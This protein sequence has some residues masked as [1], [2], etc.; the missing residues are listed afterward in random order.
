MYS[1]PTV[2]AGG[3]QAVCDGEA[4]TLLGSGATTYAWDNGITDGTIFTPTA[5]NTYTVTGTDA[6]GCLGTDAVNLT[7]NTSYYNIIPTSLCTG[8]SILAGGAYQKVSGTFYDSL[9]SSAGCDS[10]IETVLTVSSQITINLFLSVCYGDS[11]LINGN[12]ELV[13][14]TFYDTTQSVPGCDSITITNF[15][16]EPL[17]SN[18]ET[19]IICQ[20]D[21]LFLD[22]A[23]QTIAGNYVDTLSSNGCDSILTTNLIVYSEIIN[24]IS[25]SICQGDSMFLGGFF[26]KLP[27][28]YVDTLIS[29][30]GCDSILTTTLNVNNLPT[31]IAGVD[32]SICNGDSLTLL[33]S[34]AN[35][36]IWNNGVIN[37]LA[38]LPTVTTTYLVIGTD[39]NG[40]TNTDSIDITLNDFPSV[41]AGPDQIICEGDQVNFEFNNALILKG[42]LDL[43]GSGNPM[44]SGTD[45]KAIHLKANA[46]ISDLSIYSLDVV[47]NG[48]GL[49]NSSEY[50][51]SFSF[52]LS[53]DTT[54]ISVN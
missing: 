34:G 53:S 20:G 21:S 24:N 15:T 19:T 31:V 54:I 3:D 43:H 11:A 2:S 45:G 14:N 23:Y 8:D 1:L 37:G 6:N 13:S 47:S 32:Q 40:C 12:Y 35:T 17:I 41:N 10:I 49:L 36:Y 22:G 29:S 33:G 44:Y 26:Q 5:T 25:E 39:V 7:V 9:F 42:V 50:V 48:G 4:I 52:S 27:G 30:N 46:Y 51:L 38:F 28:D 16:V 18:S